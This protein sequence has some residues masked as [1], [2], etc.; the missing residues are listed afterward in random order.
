VKYFAYGSNMLSGR[1]T[2]R[3]PGAVNLGRALL[4]DHRLAW[5]KV[6]IDGSGKCDVVEDPGSV[7]WGVLY[8]I[9]PAEKPALDRA[10]GLGTGYSEKT[11]TVVHGGTDVEARTYYALRTDAG[12]KPYAWYRDIVLAGAEE[13]GLPGEYLGEI[14]ACEAIRDPDRERRSVNVRLLHPDREDLRREWREMAPAWIREARD[15]R[16]PTRTGLLD[17]YML[18]ACGDVTGLR[19]L[20]CGCGEGRFCRML[21][22]RGAASALGLDLC[23]P[24]IEAALEFR[25]GDDEYRVA[26]AQDL[27]FLDDGSF[28][29]A[30]SYLNQCDLPDFQA[31]NREVF[32]VLK[33]GGR[34]VVANLH[35]MR[36]AAGFWHRSA[37]GAKEHVILD[38]YFD[39]DQRRW[40][41]MN[42][43]F[44][45]FHRS[46]STYVKGFL[47]AG[48]VLE[49]LAEPTIAAE[50]LAE[51][52][53]L[54][55]ELRVPN[56]IV[57]ALVKP[58]IGE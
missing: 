49:D 55:D 5:H 12:M 39:E 23:E 7:V 48:F 4:R 50:R 24:M 17:G 54:D 10:E 57:Y 8:E 19:V 33:P 36:S 46:L 15:G 20:D 56:F 2:A 42:V 28:D 13:N 30:V 3:V 11:V 26:D 22:D 14:G 35:P 37:D 38:R 41:M 40:T 43:D 1:M 53:E 21:M 9:D 27:G 51:F 18:D 58:L 29:L 52:P 32:R 25:T 6:N 47:D 16:N 31:N 45:N 34:F 44:T